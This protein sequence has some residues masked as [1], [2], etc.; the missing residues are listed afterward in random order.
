MDKLEYIPGD[1]ISVYVGV[2]KYIVEVIGT[3]NE[4]EVLSYQIKFPTGEIQYADKDNIVPIPLT[5]EILEKNGWKNDGYDWYKLPT[6]RAYLYITKDII[7]LGEFLV[8]VGL[9]RHNLASINFV[10]QLQHI[11]FGLR[12]NSEM[13]V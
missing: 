2:K 10:H 8:C 6:K 7:T 9:D 5:P 12:L 11:L 3:E 1:F 13:E 4:N